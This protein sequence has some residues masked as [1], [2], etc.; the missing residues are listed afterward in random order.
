MSYFDKD[1]PAVRVFEKNEAG[2]AV[3]GTVSATPP[4]DAGKFAKGCA[5][6]DTVNGDIY[7]NTGTTASPSWNSSRNIV[8]AE[9]G[10]GVIS[11]EHL[12][13]GLTASHKPVFAGKVTWTGGTDTKA[14]VVTGA[15]AADIVVA[16]IST[17]PTEAAY[18]VS[19]APS[20]D[21][22]TFVLSAANTTNDAVISYVVFRAVT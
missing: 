11:L 5:L 1:I 15:L 8:A 21:A 10:N 17:V 6:I 20:E 2:L 22:V 4:T 18:L 9:I 14:A 12:D 16:S 13:T 3:F 19:A 7:L